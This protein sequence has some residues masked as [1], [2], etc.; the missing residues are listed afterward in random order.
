M[1]DD[2]DRIPYAVTLSR[3]T[4]WNVYENVGVAIVTVVA[5]LAGVLAGGVHLAG[6]MLVHEGSVLLVI[7][8]GTRL[9]R[10]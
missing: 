9:L 8:N 1:A 6:G 3:A 4:R 5:L 7:L 10:Y 2:L